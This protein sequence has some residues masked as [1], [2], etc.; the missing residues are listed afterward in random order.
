VKLLH[1]LTNKPVKLLHHL[2]R[3][4]VNLTTLTW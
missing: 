1:H 4:V 3:D 2:S